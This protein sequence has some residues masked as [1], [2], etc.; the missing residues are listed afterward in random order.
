MEPELCMQNLLRPYRQRLRYPQALA[1]KGYRGRREVVHSA[2]DAYADGHHDGEKTV[3]EGEHV[4]ERNEV[5]PLYEQ[6]RSGDDKY[7]SAESAV[8]HVRRA[9]EKTRE[10]TVQQ[11]G[12]C[13]AHFCRLCAVFAPCDPVGG[14]CDPDKAVRENA[15]GDDKEDYDRERQIQHRKQSAP[16]AIADDVQDMGRV[17]DLFTDGEGVNYKLLKQLVGV[18]ADEVVKPEEHEREDDD[19][20]RP[21]LEV[22]AYFRDHP[23][24]KAGENKDKYAHEHRQQQTADN[25][26]DSRMRD[27]EIYYDGGQ[28]DDGAEHKPHEV[29]ARKTRDEDIPRRDRQ[30]EHKIVI[31]GLVQARICVENAAEHT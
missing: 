11:G 23:A 10:L 22:H 15:V 5:L 25:A 6:H 30:R 16:A 21:A 2:Y 4:S 14:R 26:F 19:Y 12:R 8:E 1:L 24:E 3:G 18:K 17:H 28:H 7:G 27:D 13:A 20:K 29:N 31:L 9:C